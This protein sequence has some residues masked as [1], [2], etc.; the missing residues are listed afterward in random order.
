M[1]A[2]RWAALG[3]LVSLQMV[4]TMPV[5]HLLAR[6]DLV[7]G[8]TGWHRYNLINQCVERWPEWFLLGTKD[9]GHWGIQLFDITNQYVF[10]AVNGGMG[11]LA[12][13]V[14]AIVIAFK[15]VGKMWRAVSYDKEL[16]ALSWALGVCMWVHCVNFIGVSYFGQMQFSWY[17]ILATITSLSEAVDRGDDGRQK[18]PSAIV[19]E[20]AEA[21]TA[22][23]PPTLGRPPARRAPHRP[24]PVGIGVPA[25]PRLRS[26]RKP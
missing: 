7:G 22:A 11:A 2:V 5:W 6:I 9:T 17:L 8:S 21:A 10:E 26:L 1:R 4:M 18:V 23:G 15:Y 25:A 13:F 20:P 12:L 24:E 19:T 3:T 16:L 14:T